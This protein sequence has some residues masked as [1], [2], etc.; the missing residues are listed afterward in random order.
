MKI[1]QQILSMTVFYKT[2]KSIEVDWQAKKFP[3]KQLD[4]KSSHH[5]NMLQSPINTQYLLI[6]SHPQE[7]VKGQDVHMPIL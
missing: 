3:K 7:D 1:T 2:S 6:S 4:Q 5:K